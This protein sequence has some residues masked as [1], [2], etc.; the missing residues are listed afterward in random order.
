MKRNTVITVLVSMALGASLAFV[1]SVSFASTLTTPQVDAILGFLRAFDV[2]QAVVLEVEN[3]LTPQAAAAAGDQV[4]TPDPPPSSSPVAAVHVSAAGSLYRASAIG[5]D[6]SFNTVAYPVIPF[7]F[8][9]VGVTGG[10]AFVHNVRAASE[11]SWAKLSSETG[12]TVYMNLNAP[13]GS[14]VAGHISS[15]KECPPDALNTH[16]SISTSTE[17]TVCDGY[18]YGYNAA[19]DAYA[20]AKSSGIISPLWW[21]D[22]EEAN[23]WSDTSAVNDATIQGAIDYLNTKGIR[24]GIYS[25][26]F[27]WQDIAGSDFI[28]SQTIGGRTVSTPNWFPVGIMN[29]TDALNTCVTGTGFISDSPI[30]IVQ[31]E[32]SPT[33]VD[34]NVAC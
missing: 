7:G 16:S 1:P 20:Y 9:V 12:P 28:P 21:L 27:M 30:W 3:I 26:P 23:S 2:A 5:Y 22:I 10:K 24:I 4:T 18:N 19:E 25:V 29:E 11:Y 13:Y 32:A 14:A 8:G 6:L 17:P 15:P 31:Y 33:A 34:Q